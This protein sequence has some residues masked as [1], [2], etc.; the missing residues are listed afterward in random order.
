MVWCVML[1]CVMVCYGVVCYGVVCVVWCVMLWF[2]MVW[3]ALCI[4]VSAVALVQRAAYES[5]NEMSGMEVQLA[6]AG[7]WVRERGQW[8]IMHHGVNILRNVGFVMQCDDSGRFHTDT[9]HNH[10]TTPFNAALWMSG[11]MLLA[12]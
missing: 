9:F 5:E 11:L 8:M 1:W 10:H 2:V 7:G 4:M 6:T 12:P 3:C